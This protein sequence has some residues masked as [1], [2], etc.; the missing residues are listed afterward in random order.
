MSQACS[1]LVYKPVVNMLRSQQQ[2]AH[3]LVTI[4][5]INLQHIVHQP[6]AGLLPI[7]VAV[8]DSYR[9]VVQ[10]SGIYT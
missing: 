8:A 7:K 6:V 5:L 2:V 4:L 10:A 3:K 1:K 9:L